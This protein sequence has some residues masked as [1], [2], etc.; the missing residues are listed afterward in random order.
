MQSRVLKKELPAQI[1]EIADTLPPGTPVELWFQDEMRIGQKNTTVYQWARRGTRP[2]QPADQRYESVY[3]F[4]ALCPARDTG[5]ALVLPMANTKAMVH[6]LAEI[7]ATVAPGSHA[8]IL[9]DQAGWHTTAKLDVP[10]NLS[11]VCIPPATPELNPAENVWQ[12]LRQTYLGN[13][14]FKDYEDI[15]ERVCQAWRALL[16]EP[17]RIESITARDWACVDQYL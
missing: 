12:Y 9:L 1:T 13:R 5:A 3:L 16:A 6:H 11:L 7:S 8:I 17:G 15:I 14:V 4:G 2:R 10:H